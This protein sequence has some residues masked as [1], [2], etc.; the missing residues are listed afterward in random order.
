MNHGE[1]QRR[2][3]ERGYRLRDR[4]VDIRT[5]HPPLPAPMIGRLF[6]AFK[7]FEEPFD[8]EHFPA[9]VLTA[10][11]CLLDADLFWYG[12]VDMTR[13]RASAVFDSPGSYVDTW[14]RCQLE[15]NL[16]HWRWTEPGFAVKIS[17]YMSQSELHETDVYEWYLR[18]FGIEH[19]LC[20]P[21]LRTSS[22]IASIGFE[23]GAHGFSE[24]HRYALMLFSLYLSRCRRQCESSSIAHAQQPSLG[25]DL[26]VTQVALVVVG[27][28]G[29]VRSM[30]SRA[31]ELIQRYV[32][33][34]PQFSPRL[35][36]QL[37][38]QVMD[39]VRN[40]S[41][42]Y[43]GDPT[44]LE[45]F[46][47]SDGDNVSLHLCHREE[48]SNEELAQALGTTPRQAEV[49]RYLCQGKSKKRIAKELGISSGTVRKHVEDLYGKL[50]VS[51]PV[52]AVNERNELKVFGP[53]EAVNELRRRVAEYLRQRGDG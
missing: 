13:M 37:G 28:D 19:G 32:G 45:V 4:L 43:F 27:L 52:S 9:R 26:S 33:S 49:G 41:S 3:T 22:L 12:E 18:P 6:R 39:M 35:P 51:A 40:R 5:S 15:G 11:K 10:S 21:L 14:P 36:G 7:M 17:D 29:R 20:A 16:S 23:R 30:S 42:L 44:S 24:E 31:A 38:D 2:I 25:D 1:L 8:L 50:K 53:V 47:M 48:L 46:A 34:F